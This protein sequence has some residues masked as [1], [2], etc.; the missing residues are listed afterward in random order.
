MRQLADAIADDL[1]NCDNVQVRTN[2]RCDSI[3]FDDATGKAQ[4]Q[5]KAV[6]VESKP[7][8]FEL[9][10]AVNLCSKLQRDLC[11]NMYM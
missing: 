3:A 9:S 8:C 2:T 5:T 4:V 6:V 1:S 10:Y 11:S 7:F